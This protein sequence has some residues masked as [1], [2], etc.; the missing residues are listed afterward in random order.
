MK[1]RGFGG[2]SS[3]WPKLGFVIKRGGTPRRRRAS[4]PD[5]SS[6]TCG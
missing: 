1:S 4:K 3:G 6:G 5:K 2:M